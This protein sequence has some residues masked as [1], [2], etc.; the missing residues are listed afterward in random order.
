MFARR[1]ATL[2][3]SSIR[4]FMASAPVS[5]KLTASG[6]YDAMRSNGIDGF[7][8]EHWRSITNTELT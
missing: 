5:Q 8:G 7:Y 2:S 1:A 6:F 3:K 4:T